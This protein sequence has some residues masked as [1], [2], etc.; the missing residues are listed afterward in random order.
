MQYQP[1]PV[2]Y[3]IICG[4]PVEVSAQVT[5]ALQAGWLPH[6]DL[7]YAGASDCA[8]AVVKIKLIPVMPPTEP[9]STILVPH[10]VK[11]G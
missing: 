7:H 2:E 5:E 6:G 9:E 11:R 8:Q 4:T 10:V 3:Q 1:R